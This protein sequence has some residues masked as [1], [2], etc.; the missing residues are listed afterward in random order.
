MNADKYG[1]EKG[2]TSMR[3]ACRCILGLRGPR[4]CE[5]WGTTKHSNM[6]L[7]R[8]LNEHTWRLWRIQTRQEEDDN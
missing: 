1:E 4:L 7:K 8:L 5:R 6:K 2:C 3:R